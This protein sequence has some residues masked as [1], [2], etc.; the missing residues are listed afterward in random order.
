MVHRG[1]WRK[2][3]EKTG[4]SWSQGRETRDTPVEGN[5]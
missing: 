4:V 5:G 2:F 3:K 1:S